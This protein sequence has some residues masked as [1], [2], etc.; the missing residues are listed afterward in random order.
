VYKFA[1]AD[2]LDC[3]RSHIPTSDPE[4]SQSVY[5]M[6]LARYLKTS[7]EVCGLSKRLSFLFQPH[8]P[9]FCFLEVLQFTESLAYASL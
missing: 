9:V 1:D 3:I 8:M 4:L 5:E 2:Q 6:V 7:H